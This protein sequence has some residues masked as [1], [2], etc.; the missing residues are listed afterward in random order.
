MSVKGR[1]EGEENKQAIPSCLMQKFL[2]V[3][4]YWTSN[5]MWA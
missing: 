3:C 5:N 1:R 2:K 4:E